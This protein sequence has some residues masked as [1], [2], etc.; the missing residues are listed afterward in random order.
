[1]DATSPNTV[2]TAVLRD[3]LSRLPA[4][5]A[6]AELLAQTRSGLIWAGTGRHR[7]RITVDDDQ[8]EAAWVAVTGTPAP[9]EPEWVC[10]YC[11]TPTT[12]GSLSC[13][14]CAIRVLNGEDRY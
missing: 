5:R 4:D 6:W 3:L 9:P 2:V 13:G 1:M 12:S 14:P 10:R 8:L 7:H 11:G